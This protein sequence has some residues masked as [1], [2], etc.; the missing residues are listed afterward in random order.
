MF[1]ANRPRSSLDHRTLAFFFFFYF[2]WMCVHLCVHACMCGVHM[3]GPKVNIGCVSH[4]YYILF[5]MMMIFLF[6]TAS[7]SVNL[8]FTD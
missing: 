8:L 2:F 3:W 4:H 5:M 6:E 1:E 7:L